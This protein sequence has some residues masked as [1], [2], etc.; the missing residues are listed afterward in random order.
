MKLLISSNA[1]SKRPISINCWRISGFLL[2]FSRI[3]YF[4]SSDINIF[5]FWFNKIIGIKINSIL[6]SFINGIQREVKQEVKQ[7]SSNQQFH[8]FQFH[9]IE[10]YIK[11]FHTYSIQK[12][13]YQIMN[14]LINNKI[15]YSNIWICSFKHQWRNSLN[16]RTLWYNIMPTIQ[17]NWKIK[18]I[19]IF[20]N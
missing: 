19:Y 18:K 9:V 2:I 8:L 15:I 10:G 20:V 1:C 13:N 6:N 17:F 4:P 14:K 12:F 5:G 16:N 7:A 11:L 3:I